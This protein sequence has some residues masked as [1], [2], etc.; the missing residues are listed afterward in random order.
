MYQHLKLP[1]PLILVSLIALATGYALPRRDRRGGDMLDAV[2][3]VQRQAPL[4]LISDP[5]PAA[6][7]ARTGALYLCRT[8]RTVEEMEGLRRFPGRSD[9]RWDGVVCFKGTADLHQ[10]YL[11]IPWVSE[12][13]DHCIFYGTFA[14]FGDPKL[15][16]KIRTIL[17]SKGFQPLTPILKGG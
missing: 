13:G 16:A 5:M 14:V 8:S 6:N 17:A 11:Y 7:W 9:P 1:V 15:L 4:F 10:A 3:A 12:G 2:M